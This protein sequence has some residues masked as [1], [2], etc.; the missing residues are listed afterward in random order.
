MEIIIEKIYKIESEL[1]EF[2]ELDVEDKVNFF[3]LWKFFENDCRKILWSLLENYF[4]SYVV[5]VEK[6]LWEV[7]I[8]ENFNGIIL[9]ED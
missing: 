9:E 8:L 4:L 7:Y 5:F 2:L 1:S 3:E 6:I